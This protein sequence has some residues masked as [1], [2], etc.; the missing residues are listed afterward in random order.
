[1]AIDI[2]CRKINGVIS[3]YQTVI[4]VQILDLES[5]PTFGEIKELFYFVKKM[6]V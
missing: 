6:S 1:M 4:I 2:F 3:C 5:I